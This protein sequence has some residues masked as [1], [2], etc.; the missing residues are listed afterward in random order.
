MNDVNNRYLIVI[1]GDRHLESEINRFLHLPGEAASRVA[2]RFRV[3]L[4]DESALADDPDIIIMNSAALARYNS[5]RINELRTLKQRGKL[6]VVIREKSAEKVMEAVQSGDGVAFRS[7]NL[8]HL[9][10]IIALMKADHIV[11]PTSIARAMVDRNLRREIL[12]SLTPGEQR[13]LRLIGHGCTNAVIAAAMHVGLGRVKYL[14]RALLKKLLL[15]NRTQAA[16]LVTR[17]APFVPDA[18]GQ[19]GKGNGV[20]HS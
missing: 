14:I 8:H 4:A 19:N 15:Q 2:H 11:I 20:S 3:A 5:R 13:L 9:L 7:D 18:I 12:Q 17:E 6:L 16:V 1:V 10:A